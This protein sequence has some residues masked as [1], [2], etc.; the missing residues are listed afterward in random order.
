MW[1][2]DDAHTNVLEVLRE[3]VLDGCGWLDYN[4]TRAALG[5]RQTGWYYAIRSADIHCTMYLPLQA[6]N[7]C[8]SI[9]DWYLM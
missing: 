2:V 5:L 6:L 7:R 1:A 4:H 9:C 8:S 3:Y